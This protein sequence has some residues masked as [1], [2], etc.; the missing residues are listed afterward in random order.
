MKKKGGG[1][2]K[3]TGKG[4][5]GGKDLKNVKTP[6]GEDIC[7]KYN[8]GRCNNAKCGRAHCCQV[9]LGQHPACECKA[10]Q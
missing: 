2:G 1:K 3:T 4:K 9:C 8:Q 5:G 6:D 10:V 7:F